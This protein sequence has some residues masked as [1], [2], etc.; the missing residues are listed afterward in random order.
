MNSDRNNSGVIF[1]SLSL[2]PGLLYN[3][4]SQAFCNNIVVPVFPII[5]ASPILSIISSPPSSSISSSSSSISVLSL[6]SSDMDMDVGD[7]I[8]RN[9]EEFIITDMC[10]SDIDSDLDESYEGTLNTGNA[11]VNFSLLKNLK[12]LYYESQ[13]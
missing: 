4:P 11:I 8:E 10:I 1:T 7:I 9:G 6:P 5:F 3:S 12:F 2:G 13:K